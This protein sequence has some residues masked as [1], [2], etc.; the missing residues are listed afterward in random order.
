MQ[1]IERMGANAREYWKSPVFFKRLVSFPYI[2]YIIYRGKKINKTAHLIKCGDYVYY[3]TIWKCANSTIITAIKKANG[4]INIIPTGNKK[5]IKRIRDNSFLFTFVRNPYERIVSVYLDKVKRQA[6][7]KEA[8]RF[9]NVLGGITGKNLSF[10]EFVEIISKVPDRLL[11]PHLRSYGR[12]IEENIGGVDFV[13]KLENFNEDWNFISTIL[14]LPTSKDILTI[15]KNKNKY[16]FED[17]YTP[18][19]KTIIYNKYKK[20]FETF[21]YKKII[22]KKRKN[23]CHVKN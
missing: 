12:L 7:S 16:N 1:L 15:N 17:Y 23:K 18:S 14:N 8:Y 22:K 19:L 3:L 20:D 21:G 2:L 9:N 10:K 11:D 4:K 5:R 6:D 13:G